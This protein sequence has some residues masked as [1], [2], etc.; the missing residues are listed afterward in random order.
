MATRG[1]KQTK[2]TKHLEDKSDLMKAFD[3]TLEEENKFPSSEDDIREGK[4][5]GIMLCQC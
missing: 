2:K 1:R 3:F 5:N 4:G